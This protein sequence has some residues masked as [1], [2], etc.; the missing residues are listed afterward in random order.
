MSAE[1]EGADRGCSMVA[2]LHACMR[3]WVQCRRVTVA[4]SNCGKR[5]SWGWEGLAAMA[6]VAA[7]AAAA[8]F[9]HASLRV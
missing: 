5:V 4:Y 9:E 2:G 1:G 6:E 8:L 7:A 3:A